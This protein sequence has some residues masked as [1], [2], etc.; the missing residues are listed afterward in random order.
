M[1]K[2]WKNQESMMKSIGVIWIG[3]TKTKGIVKFFVLSAICTKTWWLQA[4]KFLQMST[5]QNSISIF[6]YSF[7]HNNG[8]GLIFFPK[9]DFS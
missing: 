7:D 8:K 6:F 2:I 3:P 1:M 9:D 5:Q 4:P